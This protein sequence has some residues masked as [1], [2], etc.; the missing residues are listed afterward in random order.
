MNNTDSQNKDKLKFQSAL[1]VKIVI[2]IILGIILGFLFKIIPFGEEFGRL[3]ITLGKLFSNF[4]SFIVPLLVVGLVAPGIGHLGKDAGKLLLITVAIAY[5][6]TLFSGFG[7]YFVT[8][9][10]YP[11]M[12]DN[13]TIFQTN[14]HVENSIAPYFTLDMPPVLSV[15][16]ALI[17]AFVIGFG[18]AVT[19]TD[20]LMDVIDDLRIIINKIIVSV[21]IPLLPFYILTIFMNITYVGEIGKVLS[22]FVKIIILIFILTVVLLLIFFSIA[23]LVAKKNPI[24]LLRKMMPAYITALG[25]SSSAAT[26]P[27]T[28]EATLSNGVRRSIASFV[29]PLCA[30][31]NLSGSMLKIVACA[32]A[33]IYTHGMVIEYKVVEEIKPA[34]EITASASINDAGE[35]SKVNVVEKREVVK[36]TEITFGVIVAFIFT[37]AVAMVAAPG[38]PGGAI[39][40]AQA[41][42]V[43]VLGFSPE[44]YAVMVALY[45]VMDSFGTATNVTG[46]GAVAIIIDKIYKHDHHI[47]EDETEA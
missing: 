26:I 6:F 39:V 34:T 33:I 17:F 14:A 32:F 21:I 29:I 42:L 22:V 8:S 44:L 2:A 20:K 9:L 24:H 18:L 5:I 45:L 23:G 36:R 1:L 40:T 47:T 27:V 19:K 35:K 11:F 37:L 12:L 30:T 4:L 25:T 38:V 43:G 41:A 7:T 31:I 15:T 3:L 13:A 28:L 16:S 46:D 10:I